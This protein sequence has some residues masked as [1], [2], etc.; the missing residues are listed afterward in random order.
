MP[1]TKPDQH[2]INRAGK[3]LV[4]TVLEPLGWVVNEVQEDYGIDYNVQLFEERSPTGAWFHVQL[5]SSASTEYS[6]DGSFISQEISS[7]HARHYAQELRDPILILLADVTKQ[8]LYWYA[9]QL[10]R[11]LAIKVRNA[12]AKSATVRIP[13]SQGLPGSAP[14]LL[15]VLDR[16]YLALSNREL[17]S[18]TRNLFAESLQ[19]IPDQQSSY[20]AFQEKLDTVRLYRIRDLFREGKL[21]EARPRADALLAD[22]DS[23]VETK[24]WARVQLQSIDFSETM[25]AGKPQSELPKV[26][27]RHARALQDLTASGPNYLK[28]YSLITRHAAELGVLTHDVIGVFMGLHQHLRA[29]G[30]P[31][32]ALH[33]YIRRLALTK[34]IISKYNRCVRLARYAST[35]RDRWMLGRALTNIV[36]A[37]LPYLTTLHFE[38]NKEAQERFEASAL[39]LCKVAQ[40]IAEETGDDEAKILAVMSALG[41]A[42]SEASAA[43]Q[44]AEQ[45]V[46]GLA[47]VTLREE[48]LDRMERVAKRWRG[49]RVER[50]YQGEPVW[51]IIQNIS[52]SLGIDLSAEGDP[53]VQSLRIAAKDNNPERVLSTCGHVMVSVGAVGPNAQLVWRLFNLGTA[54]SKVVHCTLHDYHREARELDDA[55]S[56]FKREYCDSCPDKEPRPDGWRYTDDVRQELESRHRK[57]IL[58][59]RGTPNGIRYSEVD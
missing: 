12:A 42:R 59:L 36:N 51:Q 8:M 31:L 28:F 22:P 5:K 24:F 29:D 16:A 57:F 2:D 46:Q 53:L 7:S 48:A 55:F 14:Q 1:I 40:W 19:H 58:R 26:L 43:Y 27:L 37:I 35:Y 52:S 41:V 44:W 3:R 32:L 50:D 49:E 21:G 17:T 18:S 20:R 30:D 39:Q 47:H 34:Q 10:D 45:V 25:H 54:A 56:E 4:R 6:G 13:T 38:G 15:T 33:L 9:P 11:E 23:G